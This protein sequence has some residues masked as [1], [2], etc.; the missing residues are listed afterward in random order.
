MSK[1]NAFDDDGWWSSPKVRRYLDLSPSSLERAMKRPGFPR[2]IKLPTGRWRWRGA[3]IKAW[4][5]SQVRAS[6]AGAKPPHN[7]PPLRR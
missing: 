4:P 5:I 6:A 3:E 7:D 1:D 2:P